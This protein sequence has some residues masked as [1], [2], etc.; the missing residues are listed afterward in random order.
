MERISENMHYS[1]E[2]IDK[3]RDANDIVDVIGQFVHLEKKGAS[4]MGL[5]PFHNEKSPSFSVNGSMQ[6]FHCFGCG[7]SGNVYTFLMKHENMSFPEAVKYLAERAGITLPT[8]EYTKEARMLQDKKERLFQIYKEAATY[9]YYLLRSPHGA[10]ALEYFRSRKLSDETMKNF[11][12]G[13]SDATDESLYKYLKGK[14]YDDEILRDSRL[15]IFDEKH[16]MHDMFW[17]R[18]MFPIQDKNGKVIAFGGRVMGDGKPKYVNSPETLIFQKRNTIFGFNISKKTSKGY[19]IFCE[20]YMDVISLHQAGYD[21]ACASLGTALTIE[22]A[23]EVK[24]K[25]FTK[26]YLSYDSDGAGQKATLRAVPIFHSAG[27]ETKVI[28]MSPYKDPDEFMKGLG[29]EEYEKRIEKA[30]NGYLFIIRK[31]S[32]KYDLSDPTEK[33][34]FVK[35]V[36]SLLLTLSPGLERNS[37]IDTVSSRYD[38]RKD[39]INSAIIFEAENGD[40]NIRPQNYSSSFERNDENNL[41]SNERVGL[42]ASPPEEKNNFSGDKDKR[43]KTLKERGYEESERVLLSLLTESPSDLENVSKFI[44]PSDF[45]EGVFRIAATEIF[46]EIK[47]NNEV[48]AAKVVDLFSSASEQKEAGNIFYLL[49]NEIPKGTERK[50][51]LK[52]TVRKVKEGSI[53]RLSKGESSASVNTFQKLLLEK[54]KLTDI[55]KYSF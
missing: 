46:S 28:N 21:N 20:G 16:G 37:Y 35:E 10:K 48:N 49:E 44:E 19:L 22:Q 25:K 50:K 4:Y 53:E 47:E 33:T 13:Y 8:E 7:E 24:K 34:N 14:G 40:K 2:I 32:E 55:D 51:L 26:V 52:Q 31:I 11:G 54:K 17:N 9:Y 29:A 12:L 3:V 30:E 39:D 27:I 43:E 18:A 42:K 1:D 45:S 6:I 38:V 23:N 5:C 15:V 36:V 41:Y